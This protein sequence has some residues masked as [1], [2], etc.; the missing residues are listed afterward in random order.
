MNFQ[1]LASSPR[2]LIEAD[3]TPIQG[4]RF[5]PTGFPDLGPAAYNLADG[6]TMV[7][8]ESAQSIANRLEIVCFDEATNDWSLP[9]RGLPFVRVL[10]NQGKP[11][12]NSV[13]ESHRINSPYILEGK[14]KTFFDILKSELGVLEKGR[15]DNHLL[16]KT[17]FKYDVNALL[18]GVFLAKKELAGG[19]LRLPRA[20]SG[21]VEA[22]NAS[23]AA[24]GG[25]K[26][27]QVDPSGETA[28]G[29]GHV[30][31]HRDE[32]SAEQVT[33]FFNLDLAQLRGY[34]LGSA[35]EN[36]LIALAMYKIQ[37][38]LDRGLRFRTA[39]DLEVKGTLRVKR[40]AE[41]ELPSLG[42]LEAH[43]PSLI[44]AAQPLFASPSVTDVVYEAAK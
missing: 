2:L 40:P 24:S 15:V 6:T 12:T 1:S 37:A 10:D 18:H 38:F 41:F 20:L 22:R 32:Y 16:A 4:T 44:S 19:R 39:C 7:L 11:L 23:I 28:K 9:L 34:G 30:P 27:D 33:A 14:N 26:F 31:F 21:F 5:Q 25:V 42:E 17:L 43:L 35:A 13:M 29:F 8:V 36:L 3:L